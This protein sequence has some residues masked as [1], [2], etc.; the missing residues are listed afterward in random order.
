MFKFGILGENEC[1]NL[2]AK[3]ACKTL[4]AIVFFFSIQPFR[5][6]TSKT[7]DYTYRVK[8]CSMSLQIDVSLSANVIYVIHSH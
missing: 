5:Y 6:S 1:D 3:H 4:I 8:L 7:S 2:E